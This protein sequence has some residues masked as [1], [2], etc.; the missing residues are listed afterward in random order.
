MQDSELDLSV[1]QDGHPTIMQKS[2]QKSANRINE[3]GISASHASAQSRYIIAKNDNASVRLAT[4][5][6][7]NVTTNNE[8]ESHAASQN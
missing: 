5:L 7:N 3:V 6:R 2:M 4:R 8:P 1:A